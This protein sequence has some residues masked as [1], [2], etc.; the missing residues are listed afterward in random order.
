MVPLFFLA[1]GFPFSVLDF[2][3]LNRFFSRD[4]TFFV[5]IN[6]RDLFLFRQ[7]ARGFPFRLLTRYHRIFRHDSHPDRETRV[8]MRAVLRFTHFSLV[9]GQFS[10]ERR[11]I[12]MDQTASG[13]T[14][15][16]R[17]V[18]RSVE[19]E[20]L[21]R[22]I[23]SS[24]LR[25][26]HNREDNG[27][28][29][30]LFNVTVRTTMRSHRAFFAFVATRAIVGVSHFYY[31]FAPRQAID[32]ASHPSVRDQR[33]LRDALCEVSVFASGVKVVARRFLPVVFRVRFEISRATVRH[34]MD[35]R[36]VNE[37]RSFI[38]QVMDSR[39][40]Q[41][42]RRQ[43]R[44]RERL[45]ATRARNISFLR[46]V[47]SHQGAIVPV[48]RTRDL[49][50]SSG[51]SVQVLLTRRASATHVVQLRVIR[52]RGVREA[53]IRDVHCFFRR[54]VKVARVRHVSRSHFLI[55]SRVKV[56]EC[57]VEREPRVLGGDFLPII[58]PCV[59]GFVYCFFWLVRFRGWGLGIRGRGSGL[60]RSFSGPRNAPCR[61]S[62]NR[63]RQG[64][65]P[66]PRVRRRVD[67]R[68]FLV[69]FRGLGRRTQ[70]RCTGRGCARSGPLLL[71]NVFFRMRPRA[72]GRDRRVT[73]N[74]VGLYEV[75]KDNG[76][77]DYSSFPDV[78]IFGGAGPPKRVYQVSMCFVVRRISRSS[79]D[80][81]GTNESR[82]FIRYPGRT[83]VTGPLEVGVSNSSCARH[84]PVA[85]GSAL[86]GLRGFRQ[87]HR[88]VVQYVGR[89]VPRANASGYSRRHVG[90]RKVSP[91][92]VRFLS[93]PR[94]FRSLMASRRASNGHRSMPTCLAQASKGS[95]KID[96]PNGGVGRGCCVG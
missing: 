15:V 80:D 70:A 6:F 59:M 84:S 96:H 44:V 91:Y 22:V 26:I 42:I 81:R 11:A 79:R 54:G 48:R 86:P 92:Q 37:R 85:N 40:F 63:G 68:L 57:A 65:R 8:T 52:S 67:L 7:G 34:S 5:L 60:L 69:I 87:V 21:T 4:P 31:V 43:D 29:Y 66:L 41:P 35:A 39:R 47:R 1:G 33:L 58:C 23:R 46:F 83:P 24:V 28:F 3:F 61:M 93:F 76:G 36:N 90:R 94:L 82:R 9:R 20:T 17:G 95:N 30:R 78:R 74:F 75:A 71:P 2:R 18:F 13:R 16:L 77:K 12:A 62:A 32:Q 45:I 25:P 55:R 38:D 72:G 51:L 50:I 14:L 64:A 89:A 88:V 27:H 19:Y 53:P 10:F 56:V 73:N 49:L